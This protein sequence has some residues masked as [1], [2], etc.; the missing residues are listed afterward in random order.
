MGKEYS[1][2]ELSKLRSI[3]HPKEQVGNDN[4]YSHSE[5]MRFKSRRDFEQ[6][7]DE[8]N[9]KLDEKNTVGTKTYRYN[10]ETKKVERVR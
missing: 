3:G 7:V 10:K 2:E 8:H 6:H 1:E 4:L 5:G 9:L